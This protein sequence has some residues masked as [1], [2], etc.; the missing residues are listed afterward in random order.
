M[1]ETRRR[2]TIERVERPRGLQLAHRAH[3]TCVSPRSS[4]ILLDRR[5]A[6]IPNAALGGDTGS[7]PKPAARRAAAAPDKETPLT[8]P[9]RKLHTAHRVRSRVA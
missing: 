7:R 3:N 2:R 4:L 6:I 8:T 9:H 5:N 1:Q